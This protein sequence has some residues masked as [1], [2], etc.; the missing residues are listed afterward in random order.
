VRTPAPRCA[1]LVEQLTGGGVPRRRSTPSELNTDPAGV[2]VQPR[3]LATTTP[4]PGAARW[5]LAVPDRG[6][7]EDSAAMALLDDALEGL[8]ELVELA[9]TDDV[10]D[11][12]RGG[13]LPSN[14][15]TPLPAYRLAVDLDL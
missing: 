8:L 10:I 11:L 1:A 5:W 14:P 4:S 6:T 15:T 9:D 3:D 13:A 12:S 2:W 7:T